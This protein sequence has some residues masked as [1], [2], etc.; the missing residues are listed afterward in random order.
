MSTLKKQLKNNDISI[1]EC[2]PSFIE[3]DN[4]IRIIQCLCFSKIKII[5]S[6]IFFN[7]FFPLLIYWSL[8][9]R[10]YLLFSP[11][12][13]NKTAYFW[14][15]NRDG[16]QSISKKFTTKVKRSHNI[17]IFETI[18]FRHRK[19]IYHYDALKNIFKVLELD[20]QIVHN[21]ILKQFGAGLTADLYQEYKSI[22]GM[23]LIE[24]E[25]PSILRLFIKEIFSPINF[26][27]ILCLVLWF[28]D[29]Y[30][31]YAIVVLILSICSA[32][33]NL[34]IIRS[35][36][37]NL[38]SMSK[39]ETEIEVIRVINYQKEKIIMKSIDL[40]PGD[41]ITLNNGLTLPCDC[42]LL[43]N[44]AVVN[45]ININGEAIPKI[46]TGIPYS[47]NIY[48]IY[49]KNHTLFDGTL[50]AQVKKDENLAGKTLA[51]VIRTGFY[52]VKG[53]L[54]RN[55]I[56]STQNRLF[57]LLMQM[58]K[59]ILVMFT[60]A[61]IGNI[62]KL[63][64]LNNWDDMKEIMVKFLD[65][66]TVAIAPALP[67]CIFIGIYISIRLLKKKMISCYSPY[68]LLT[69]GSIEYLF[70]DKTGTI[71]EKELN[72]KSVVM[73]YHDKFQ[74]SIS[75]TNE[76][77][78]KLESYGNISKAIFSQTLK[79][80][81]NL[82]SICHSIVEIS[83]RNEQ[84]KKEFIGDNIDLKMF[85]FSR[86]KIY[87]F[88]EGVTEEKLIPQALF[89]IKSQWREVLQDF[90]LD[91]NNQSTNKQ[92]AE[93][94]NYSHKVDESEMELFSAHI[95]EIHINP[96]E[97]EIEEAE[98]EELYTLKI[99]EFSSE[100]QRMSIIAYSKQNNNLKSYVKGSPEI[101]KDLCLP[102]SIPSDFNQKLLELTKNGFVVLGMAYKLLDFSGSFQY[103]ILERKNCEFNLTF[104]GFL[105]YEN[106]LKPDSIDCFRILNSSGVDPKI[107][108]GD[109]ATTAL[110]V[111]HKL[112]LVANL[113]NTTLID[114]AD[115]KIIV[116]QDLFAMEEIPKKIEF[117]TFFVNLEKDASKNFE[118]MFLMKSVSNQ[119]QNYLCMGNNSNLTSARKQI[120][121]G[122]TNFLKEFFVF[123]TQILESD[124][125][126][127]GKAFNYMFVKIFE[128]FPSQQQKILQILL[129]KTKIFSR[130]LPIDKANL[131]KIHQKLGFMVG[132]VGDGLND[133]AALKQADVGLSFSE[134][135]INLSSSFSTK[136]T[137]LLSFIDLLKEGRKSV[138][139]IS[140]TFRYF[141]LY[142]LIQFSN[143]NV[144]IIF[145]SGLTD[146]QYLIED[147][148]IATCLV[149]AS[150]LT[151]GS[152]ELSK[153]RPV[154]DIFSVMNI[155]FIL[156]SG[157]IQLGA[158]IG[159]VLYVRSQHWF[160]PEKETSDFYEFCAYCQETGAIFLF[161]MI[162]LIN[163]ILLTG[164][165]RPDRQPFYKNW[166]FVLLFLSKIENFLIINLNKHCF[167]SGYICKYSFPL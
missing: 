38:K 15:E 120:F 93:P 153:I 20:I 127:T 2:I 152:T 52:S 21:E 157:L 70:L 91:F 62:I 82:L 14:I 27:Q 64:Q 150:S 61:I 77:K 105:V 29:D 45:E 9:C 67:T 128:K 83:K 12:S 130:M 145:E 144:L 142:S 17:E 156:G 75:E 107:V 155:C 158:Q 163:S 84:N 1:V 159:I 141:A 111:A 73:S 36:F 22:Y 115:S 85:E 147:L 99:F 66:I 164:N 4:G 28:I 149:L 56:Y 124:I 35:H 113:N 16:T 40:V 136:R 118:R 80:L 30:K 96:Q 42:I 7:V 55:I 43:N 103:L 37:M 11:C 117:A 92:M 10:K 161:S 116:Q 34:I 134:S 49:D 32:I 89:R 76:K 94:L 95:A 24:I 129:K 51:L 123:S 166:I 167:S 68:R 87:F 71:T 39:N 133:A 90:H 46:K 69:A 31:I 44:H 6:I 53:E 148:F 59:Y 138:S 125:V 18:G 139:N 25:I 121:S 72:L 137:S 74:E 143:V 160:N 81:F 13:L 106:S 114:Y 110:V 26:L 23:C 79:E 54:F 86:G 102:S 104:L 100:V 57:F 78:L 19:M 88:K 131:I 135:N 41:V 112:G 154:F 98:Q 3:S 165:F 140:H 151:A 126:I 162:L 33:L 5:L 109:N 48:S 50:I 60:L 119:S 101:I 47:E 146:S 132:M 108:T 97:I 8:H 122:S 65:L 58:F 63:A